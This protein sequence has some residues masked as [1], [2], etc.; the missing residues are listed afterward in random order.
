[1]KYIP[2]LFCLCFLFFKAPVEVIDASQ[3]KYTAGTPDGGG[4]I[5]Y[6]LKLVANC[7]S[8]DLQ[9][10]ELWVENKSIPF[11]L[12]TTNSTKE[13]D[14]GDT[15]IIKASSNTHHTNVQKSEKEIVN[16]KPNYD[17]IAALILLNNNKSKVIE[18]KEFRKL[19]ALYYP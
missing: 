19:P 15:L 4:G 14:K 5:K 2:I 1:M 17:G 7:S 13:F 18:I 9:F 16:Q 12:F 8:S 11:N 3:Q 6:T 10:S